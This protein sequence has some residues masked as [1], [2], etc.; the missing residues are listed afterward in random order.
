MALSYVASESLM[1]L[2]PTIAASIGPAAIAIASEFNG[3]AALSALWSVT[4]PNL[5]S[6]LVQLEN[7]IAAMQLAVSLGLPSVSFDLAA[8]TSLVAS[9]NAGFPL[10]TVLEGYLNA[11]IGL[12]SY[13]W[14]GNGNALGAALTT[15]LATQWPDG[16]STATHCD[17]LIF[18]ATAGVA[19]TTLPQFFQ[20]LTFG[21]GLVYGGKIT[22]AQLCPVVLASLGQGVEALNVQLAGA[23]A[24]L[25]SLNV[26]PPSFGVIVPQLQFKLNLNDLLPS[27]SFILGALADIIARLQAKFNLVIALG[28]LLAEAGALMFVYRYS[29]NANAMGAAVTTALASTWG[30]GFTPSTGPCI[31]MIFGAVDS[32]TVT[33]MNAFFGGA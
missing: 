20:A 31:A 8:A 24:L 3:A 25:E 1:V 28:T 29:G 5:A 9:I 30:D 26:T 23:V 17:A 10:L 19:L 33:T 22:L 21:P 11:A 14:V 16:T 27:V 18:G 4:P 7:A 32:L 15:A 13:S 12:F 6:I 2:C